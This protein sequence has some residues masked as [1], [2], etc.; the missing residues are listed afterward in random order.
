MKKAIE[1]EM[2]GA[3]LLNTALEHAAKLTDPSSRPLPNPP[4]IAHQ[5]LG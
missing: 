5:F 4:G 1:E 2:A 3:L